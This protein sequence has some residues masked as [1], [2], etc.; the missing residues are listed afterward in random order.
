MPRRVV[1]TGLGLI[2][3][4]GN[5]TETS[6]DNIK[7]GRTGVGPITHYDASPYL[8]RIAA[9]VKGFKPEQHMNARE[10]RR[11]DRYQQFITVA[12]QEAITQ[13][14]LPIT[15]DTRD[16]IGVFVGTAVAG[17][18]SY[19]ELVWD[20]FKTGDA[21]AVTP[22][23]V[24]MLM[25]NGGSALVSID[26]GITGP[27][28]VLTSACASGADCIGHA[29]DMIRLGKLDAAVAGA[30][31][32]PIIPIGIAAFDRIGAC[33]REN[34]AP[35]TAVRPF[36]KDRVGLAFAEGAGVV[37]LEEMEAA[38]A[39]GAVI[40]AELVGY[41]STSDSHHITAPHPSGLGAAR[42]LRQAMSDARLTPQD[43]HYINAHGTATNLNDAMETQAVKAVFG[44]HAYHVPMSS[45][46]SMT[47]HGMGFTAAAEA[48]FSVLAIRD[49]VAPPTI[50][51]REPD[52]ACDLDYVPNT[53]REVKIDCVMSNSFGFGGHNASLIIKR[54]NE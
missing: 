10:V 20:F 31:E 26:H 32:S 43:I 54:F 9:E 33:S 30:S 4:C 47:G 48:V 37:V 42:A 49:Q 52:P 3:P 44:Q 7:H 38:K 36:S 25:G 41:G 46:K 6:W 8:V 53:A 18:S 27:S 45:T 29:F 2:T 50:N 34:D 13:S 35:E 23:A 21:R 5:T 19:F 11:R 39:R 22:F 12:A 51:L 1:I 14:G 17:V 15:D 40:L 16:R 28:Y 24:P